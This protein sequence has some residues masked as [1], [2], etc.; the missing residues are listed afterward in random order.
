VEAV[1]A[2]GA[3]ADERAPHFDEF[4]VVDGAGRLQIPPALRDEAGIG[5]R[6]TLERAEDGILIKPAGNESEARDG[7]TDAD[8]PEA[9]TDEPE[10]RGLRRWFRRGR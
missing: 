8:H 7:E 6:V 2:Q 4:V 5:D 9:Q 10:P 1:L 3:V